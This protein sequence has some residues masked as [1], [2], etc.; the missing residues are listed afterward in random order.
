MCI[1]PG[2]KLAHLRQCAN[3]VLLTAGKQ[4]KAPGHVY[5]LAGI[6]D[7]TTKIR[8]GDYQEVVFMGTPTETVPILENELLKTASMTKKLGW[9]P[10]FCTV[11]PMSLKDWNSPERTPYLVHH[12][13]Y[14]DM[15]VL[16]ENTICSANHI[17]RAINKSNNVYTPNLHNQIVRI[18][19]S[20]VKHMYNRLTDGCHPSE[21]VARE[22]VKILQRAMSENDQRKAIHHDV[23][24]HVPLSDCC[25]GLPIDESESDSDC[26]T[27]HRRRW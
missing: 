8:D 16:L 24:A 21:K 5:Y 6:P 27:P 7:L 11:T 9:V 18:N 20:K 15:Q 3:Q 12:N 14:A 19:H 13:Q 4:G 2:A 23:I 26:E 10:V 1:R 25:P 17:I 22:W